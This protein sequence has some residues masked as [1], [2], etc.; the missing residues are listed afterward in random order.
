MLSLPHDYLVER[1]VSVPIQVLENKIIKPL[2]DLLKAFFLNEL[3][4]G[5]SN[6][7][8][9]KRSDWKSTINFTLY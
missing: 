6:N 4:D 5:V 3:A 9:K 2:S 7:R 8:T 1:F